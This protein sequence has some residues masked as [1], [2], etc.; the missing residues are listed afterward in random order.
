METKKIE[1]VPDQKPV[2]ENGEDKL[3]NYFME[4]PRT[5]KREMIAD[6]HK[7]SN[8]LK[9]V[10]DNLE[11]ICIVRGKDNETIFE[12]NNLIKTLTYAKEGVIDGS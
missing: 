11:S 5:Y 1:S 6:F 4:V 8:E 10:L 12:L 3:F 7:I 2:I 9:M